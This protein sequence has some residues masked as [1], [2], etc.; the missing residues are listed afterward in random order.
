MT[1][2][3]ECKLAIA[4]LSASL[5]LSEAQPRAARS[6]DPDPPV[7][8][9]ERSPFQVELTPEGN[10]SLRFHRV[11]LVTSEFKFWEANWKWANPTATTGAFQNGKASYDL[12]IPGLA[13]EAAGTIEMQS[14]EVI[15]YDV[16][17]QHN[18]TRA[19][20]IG[21][22]IE[23]ALDLKSPLFNDQAPPDPVLSPEN[24]G[25]TWPL[26]S[27]RDIKVVFEPGVHKV[28]FE[29]NRKNRIRAFFLGETTTSGTDKLRITITLP[30]G[31]E[32][33][34]TE[35]EEYGPV[36]G[37]WL[38]N[39]LPYALSPV[40]LSTLNHQPGTHGFLRTSGDRLVFEDGTPAKFW[41]ID[42]M[43]FALF[44]NNGEIE[45]HAKR[46][47]MLGFNL[48]RLHHHD[49]MGWVDPTVINKHAANSRM[50]DERG[51]DRVDYWIKC[52]RENGIYV[53]LDMHSY[54]MFREGDRSTDLGEVAT[55]ADFNND[56][57]SHHEV[58]GY[59]Q[60][61]P[62]LQKL[63]AEFQE[64]YLTHLNRYTGLAYK[65]DPTIAFA[66]IT[67]ENDITHHYG[68]LALPRNNHPGLTQL[69]EQR[70]KV[71]AEKSGLSEN[72]MKFPWS[73]GPAKIFLNNQEHAFYSTM[74]DSIRGTGC[75]ALVAAGQMWGDNPLSSLPSI[76]TGDVIDVHEYDVSGQLTADPRYKP[77]IVSMIGINQISGK[78]LTVSEW[79]L[80]QSLEPTVDR[81]IA[82][83]YVASIAAL[84][85]WDALMLYGY[86]QQ[87]LSDQPHITS[88]WDAF[89]DPATMGSMPA[90]ALLFRNGHVSPAKKEYC[91]AL[92]RDQMFGPP[93]RPDS[94]AA[95]RTLMEQSHFSVGIPAVPELD[96]LKPSKPPESAKI[97]HEPD[98]SF[99][100]SNGSAVTSDT[101]ELRRD[102]DAGFQTIDTPKTQVAQGAIGDHEFK[103]SDVTVLVNTRHAAVA[104]S[105]LDD[106]PLR[107]SNL[108]L[109]TSI[110]RTLKP[111]R[112][113]GRAGWNQD[114]SAYSEAVHGEV[115]VRAPAGLV[116]VRLLADG[117]TLPLPD[118]IYQDGRYRIPMQKKLSLWYLLQ[119]PQS[120]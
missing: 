39:P 57:H 53:W 88:V 115:T 69:Y 21:G 72:D 86:C 74:I 83:M 2:R 81:F 34:P 48:V 101:G 114:L 14:P 84:Q 4:L 50:L 44:S 66:L 89:S 111:K 79:N 118:V 60:Y 12:R 46:L 28:Y 97:I 104:V 94:C 43:A 27:G 37:G 26:G 108:I 90:A 113:P 78:P 23:F 15:T 71:F 116:A 25:W 24:T 8:P 38:A 65:D 99:L 102:W 105:A 17:V 82:P 63:M 6:A 80:E 62:V 96:W 64:K 13:A 29:Q 35:L 41:G 22:G 47:A 112:I 59:C 103:L 7:K 30:Q 36:T 91:L 56:K 106:Q 55:F 61:D 67:N 117:S 54:R 70:L 49:T 58:K 42:V 18:A 52:L 87:P 32:R 77:N 85:G 20:V 109:V 95:A 5:L 45:R 120:K 19:G 11:P 107:S 16:T 51:I 76:T 31:T 73:P 3:T 10:F 110:A 33:K 119:R 92:S 40:D 75:K 1:V 93:L 9:A 68:V 98:E 100:P